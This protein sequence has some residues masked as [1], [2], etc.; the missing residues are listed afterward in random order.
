MEC[1]IERQNNEARLIFSGSLTFE[2][3]KEMQAALA[4]ILGEAE[5][6]TL[7]VSTV[8]ETDLSCLQLLCSAHRTAGALGKNLRLA[9]N[10]SA[11][12]N[13]V[14]QAA[15]YERHTGCCLDRTKSCL[16]V[17]SYAKVKPL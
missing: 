6:V 1:K 4:D 14:A 13:Q 16:W 10:R 7:D 5:I 3:I 2:A 15:G 11:P 8:E 12:F 17:A 9:W